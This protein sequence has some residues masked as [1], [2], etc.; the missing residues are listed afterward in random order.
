[1]NTEEKINELE[2]KIDNNMKEIITNMNKLHSHE[3]KINNNE[4]KINRNTGAIDVLHTI[5][6]YNNRFFFMWIITFFALIVSIGYNIYIISDTNVE[7]TQRIEQ[8]SE[9]GSNNYIG[10]DGDIN[11]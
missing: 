10:R 7:K 2:K 3:K 11:G 9:S 6:T 1:M 8:E 5:K 4:E